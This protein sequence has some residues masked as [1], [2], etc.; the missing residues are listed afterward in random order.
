MTSYHDW[1]IMSPGTKTKGNSAQGVLQC[2]LVLH[3]PLQLRK[4]LA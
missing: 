1:F 3:A 4:H 2:A